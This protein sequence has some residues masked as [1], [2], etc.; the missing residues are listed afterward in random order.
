MKNFEKMKRLSIIFAVLTLLASCEKFLEEGQVTA[1]TYSY[2]ETE[3]GC[4]ALVNS[5]YESLRLKPGNEWSYG[6]FNFGT[7]EYMKG[8]EWTQPYAQPEYNDYTPDLDA[9]AKGNSFVADVGD[10]WAITYKPYL[11]GHYFE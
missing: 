3:Q 10:L 7:D 6:M 5:C 2:Y 4:E 8:Y 9:E 11:P 1:L